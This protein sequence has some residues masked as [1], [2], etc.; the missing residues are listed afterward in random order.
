VSYTL[1]LF[2]GTYDVLVS[3]EGSL[4]QSVLPSSLDARVEKGCSP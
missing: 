3:S 4:E 1:K 2:S